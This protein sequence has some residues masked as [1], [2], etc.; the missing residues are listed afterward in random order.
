MRGGAQGS[1]IIRHT[2]F[3]VCISGFLIGANGAAS[4]APAAGCSALSGSFT[5]NVVTGNTASAGFSAGDVVTLTVSTAGSFT[6]I[7]L[8]GSVAG[9]LL[10]PG[11]TVGSRTYTVPADTAET[12]TIGGVSDGID[13]SAS[14]SW[15]CV[16]GGSGSGGKTDSD[17]LDNVQN[18]GSAVVANTSGANISGSVNGAIDNALNQ[19]A[20]ASSE[21]ISS[22]PMGREEFAD[23]YAWSA[24]HVKSKESEAYLEMYRLGLYEFDRQTKLGFVLYR[25]PTGYLPVRQPSTASPFAA[26]R[27]S[28]VSDRAEEAF[29][30][31]GYASVNK[32]PLR[33]APSFTSRWSTWADVRGTG[34][35]QSDS[36]LFKGTQVNATAGLNYKI[37]PNLVVGL[38]GGYENFD[39]EF[40]SLTGRLKGD[41]GTVGTYAGWQISPTLR[42]KG[43]VGW[44]GLGYDASAGT[45]AGSFDGSRWLF[46][47]G[48]TGSHRVATYII[49]P[50]ADVFAIWERQTAYTDTLGALHDARSFSSGRV[51]LGGRALAPGQGWFGATP[52]LGLY[53]DWRFASNDAQPAA[54]PFA[55]IGEGWSARVTGGFNMRVFTT[56]SLSVGGEYGGIGA[57]YKLWTG[58]ARL[59]LPF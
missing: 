4:A 7:S 42:W 12:F 33:A 14:Y 9:S 15:S 56:G 3:S 47:T 10:M 16:P 39:Y 30:A 43:M 28:N 19:P 57:D 53:G 36:S 52:Y 41:G 34:F 50:S 22:E 54:V 58:T 11:N 21:P 6:S 40:A 2:V 1:A 18:A 55:G 27:R 5:G 38:F 44:T 46:S 59:T 17:K 29:A 23:H 45:A 51:S 31:L 24:W 48:L 35:E 37:R 49:E 32:A 8:M 25:T 20:P 26:E 13:A